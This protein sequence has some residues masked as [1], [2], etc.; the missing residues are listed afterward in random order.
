MN[1]SDMKY[2][3]SAIY[4]FLMNCAAAAF[5]VAGACAMYVAGLRN[6]YFVLFFMV[7]SLVVF[8][9]LNYFYTLPHIRAVAGRDAGFYADVIESILN[10]RASDRFF[11]KT[12]GEL[13][14]YLSIKTGSILFYERETGEFRLNVY[15]GKKAYVMRNVDFDQDSYLF[16]LVT[17]PDDLIIK[18][19][20]NPDIHFEHVLIDDLAQFNASAAVPVFY[21]EMLLGLMFPGPRSKKYTRAEIDLLKM[22]ALKIGIFYIN[23]FFVSELI[24]KKE[25]EK[26]R[27]L[28]SKVQRNFLPPRDI[29]SGNIQS[30]VF[31]EAK[32]ASCDFYDMF[33]DAEREK[34]CFSAYKIGGGVTNV[35]MFMPA[36]HALQFMFAR[37]G[38]EP[39]KLVRRVNRVLTE[40]KLMDDETPLMHIQIDQHGHAE[41]YC[42]IYPRPHVWRKKTGKLALLDK[43]GSLILREGDM[44]LI[45][46]HAEK[47]PVISFKESLE[48]ML[49]ESG[50]E[51]LRKLSK[52]I[53]ALP[54]I[55][56]AQ[57][58][59][60]ILVGLIRFGM[61]E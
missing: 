44:M 4:L 45:L 19:L 16:K 29:V 11:S 60:D 49:A 27:E 24:K 47:N 37:M 53:A 31:H 1:V 59:K 21:H 14:E 8:P 33:Y 6:E 9:A 22:Y 7:L 38:F 36:L 28:G 50:H 52:R 25:L 13:L 18:H 61:P 57:L 3:L 35:S 15:N 46:S 55:K 40:K 34:I 2:F 20:L 56:E 5:L 58:E 17:S 41:C 30:A 43:S 23:G 10:V 26:E 48:A 39:E 51:S 54:S 42:G 32:G 12:F